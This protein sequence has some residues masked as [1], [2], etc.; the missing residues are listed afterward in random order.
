MSFNFKAAVTICN[1]FGAQV[2]SVCHCF[3]FYPIYWPLG[4]RTGCHD[5]SFLNVEF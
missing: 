3:H 2:N 1:D 5:L 4:D